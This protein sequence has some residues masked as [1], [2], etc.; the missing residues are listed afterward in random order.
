MGDAMFWIISL[1]V[2][3]EIWIFAISTSSR[4]KFRFSEV[5][6]PHAAM[7]RVKINRRVNFFVIVMVL[8]AFKQQVVKET[9]EGRFVEALIAYL[10]MVEVKIKK[11]VSSSIL[12]KL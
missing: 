1:M 2:S 8:M 10:D 4:F 11:E 12:T 5:R 9:S 7:N 6:W 3:G